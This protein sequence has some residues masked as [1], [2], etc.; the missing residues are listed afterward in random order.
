M[1]AADSAFG[2]GATTNLGGLPHRDAAAASAFAIGEFDIPAAP[3]LPNIAAVET[4]ALS[5][6]GLM[7]AGFDGLHAMLTLGRLVSLDGSPISW[8]LPGPLSVGAGLV[9]DGVG[10]TEAFDRSIEIVCAKL[11][12]VHAEVERV[13]PNSAQLVML[14]E[15]ALAGLMADDFPIAP[16]HAVDLISTAMASLPSQA[17]AGVHCAHPCDLATMLAAGPGVVSVPLSSDLPEWAGYLGRFLGEGGVIAWAALPTH[18]P[19]SPNVERYWRYLSDVWCDL[20]ARGCDPVALRRQSLI[21][22]GSCLDR[23]SASVARHLARMAGQV[24]NRVRDQATA[25]RF[26]LGA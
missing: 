13:M 8:R 1:I 12:E 5:G 11:Q 20:V 21:T 19:L 23:Y 16:D 22:P 7:H 10:P 6:T 2:N 9:T 17:V 26:A 25:A 15:P 14:D 3:V 18:G 4:D 24:G